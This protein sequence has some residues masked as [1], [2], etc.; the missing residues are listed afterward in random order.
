MLLSED[1]SHALWLQ[2]VELNAFLFLYLD[3]IK[4]N[5]EWNLSI[6]VIRGLF[7]NLLTSSN[8]DCLI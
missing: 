5:I 6:I 3:K 7:I 2:L 1:L 8:P 4:H